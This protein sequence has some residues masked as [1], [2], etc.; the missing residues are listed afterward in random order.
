MT[1]ANINYYNNLSNKFNLYHKN[2]INILIHLIT[3]PLSILEIISIINKISNNTLFVKTLGLIY[4]ISL[5]YNDIPFNVLCLTSY[6]ISTIV[7]ISN[8]IKMKLLYNI[9]LFI[10][11]YL[12]Q[13]LSHYLTN[14][15]TYQSSYISDNFIRHFTEHTYYLLPLIITSSIKSELIYNNT[16]LYKLLG[17]LPIL[18]VYTTDYLI[19]K[20]YIV[21]PW[22]FRE[23]KII[24]KEYSNIYYIASLFIISYLTDY[25]IFLIGTSY[26]HYIQYI[27][28]YYYRSSID[29]NKFKRDVIFYKFLSLAQ[30]YSL[31]ISTFTSFSC[32]YNNLLSII[33]II[34]SNILSGYSAY[35][36]G[37]DGCYFGIELGY[38]SKNKNYISKF[39]YGYIPHP[40]ILSQCIALYFMNN[41][42]LFY[43]NWPFLIYFHILFYLIHMIQ[44]HFDIYINNKLP[45]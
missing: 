42:M 38:I 22:D 10:V 18:F 39:P 35:L 12:A 33:I 3:T 8:K 6:A 15:A 40:M 24:K 4:Y 26:I 20:G 25:K 9:L 27:Y 13:D 16:I 2:N 43:N 41:N 44:E 36:L 45:I 11:G 32:V 28:V 37:T 5:A 29:Y 30:L 14:E 23:Y 19:S 34:S 1:D 31:Y 21:Y 7:V 17:I